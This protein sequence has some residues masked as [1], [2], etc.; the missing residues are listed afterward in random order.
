M[1][2]SQNSYHREISSEEKDIFHP[3][4]HLKLEVVKSGNLNFNEN[5][6]KNKFV[7][8]IDNDTIDYPLTLRYWKQGDRLYPYGME[9]SQLVSDILT[10][11]KISGIQRERSLVLEANERIIWLLGHRT[12]R[13]FMVTDRTKHILK[14]SWE[15]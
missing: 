1:S 14:I 6:P 2:Q 9:G 3:D 11:K 7:L 4:G 10:N 15:I 8:Y 5:P 12:S 13:H